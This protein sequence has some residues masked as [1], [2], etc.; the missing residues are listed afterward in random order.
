MTTFSIGKKY[1]VRGNS[2]TLPVSAD[3]R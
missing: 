3:V 2:L 1:T